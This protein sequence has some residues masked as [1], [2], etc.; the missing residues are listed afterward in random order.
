MVGAVVM[1]LV[2]RSSDRNLERSYHAAIP[3]MVGG[4]GLLLM[5]IFHSSVAIVALLSLLA[6]GA[7]GWCAP[8]FALPCEFLT[9]SAVAAGVALINS[10]GNIGGFVGPYATGVLSGWTGGIYGAFTL[11]GIPMLL[12]ATGLLLLPKKASSKNLAV[13]SS[14]G[15]RRY[16]V[17]NRTAFSE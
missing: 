10:I 3:V 7:Y 17:V 16:E 14:H 6:I 4:I 15:L 9:G 12:S 1:V 5:G 13:S 2:S 11:L 8:F